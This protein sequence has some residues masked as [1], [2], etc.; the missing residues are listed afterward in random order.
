MARQSSAG[1]LVV[2]YTRGAD[3]WGHS[4]TQGDAHGARLQPHEGAHNTKVH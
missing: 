4:P 1:S 2:L 3:A